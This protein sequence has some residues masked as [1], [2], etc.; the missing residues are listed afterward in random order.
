MP[1]KRES[2]EWNMFSKLKYYFSFWAILSS[3]ELIQKI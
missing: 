1:Q 2:N 3:Q